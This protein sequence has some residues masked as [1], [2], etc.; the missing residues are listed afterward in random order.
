MK[1]III[2][3]ILCLFGFFVNAQK[4]TSKTPVLDKTEELIDKYG[5]K[6]AQSF[7]STI[8]STKP[9]VKEGFNELVNFQI[10]KGIALLL[11]LLFC[12]I[13]FYIFYRQYKQIQTLLRSD[14]VPDYLDKRYGP[15]DES[16]ISPHLIV[17]F[18]FGIL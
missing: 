6:I 13:A 3:S 5:A 2:L 14:K 7:S 17:P 8:E 15:F 12:I 1:K 9:M 16:N 18:I 4:D 11:P 10:A